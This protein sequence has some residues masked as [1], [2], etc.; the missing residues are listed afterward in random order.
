M[1]YTEMMKR[2]YETLDSNEKKQ[3]DKEIEENWQRRTDTDK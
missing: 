1:E 2:Y 3:F